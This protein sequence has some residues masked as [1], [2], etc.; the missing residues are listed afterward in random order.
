[1]PGLQQTEVSMPRITV[2]LARGMGIFMM[3]LIVAIM[4]RGMPVVTATVSDGPVLPAYAI[5]SLAAG[6]AMIV[7][8]NVSSGGPLPV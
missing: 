1:V 6:I 4:L 7:C 2:L 3:T 5:L 8:H